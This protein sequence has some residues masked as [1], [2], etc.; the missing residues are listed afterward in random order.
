MV[1]EEVDTNEAHLRD[2]EAKQEEQENKTASF[3]DEKI[4][5]IETT[6]AE[7]GERIEGEER[8][9]AK[10][11]DQKLVE[12]EENLGALGDRITEQVDKA[13]KQD[14]RFVLV[15]QKMAELH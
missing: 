9:T 7:Q 1:R 4:A 3:F 8:R 6:I 11:L 5:D 14:E 15:D 10:V 13:G 12:M 2:F